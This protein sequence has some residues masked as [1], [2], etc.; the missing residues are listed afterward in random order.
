MNENEIKHTI[1]RLLA[2][3]QRR[4]N[5]E[6]SEEEGRES[7]SRSGWEHDE[8]LGFNVVMALNGKGG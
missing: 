3:Y 8:N 5:T 2:G 4:C 6:N 7:E 1:C